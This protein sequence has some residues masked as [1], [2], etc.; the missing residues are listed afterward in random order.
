MLVWCAQKKMYTPRSHLIGVGLV[1]DGRGFNLRFFKVQN[2][3]IGRRTLIG[4]AVPWGTED[5]LRQGSEA[6]SLK[7]QVSYAGGVTVY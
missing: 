2:G 5:L 4:E 1:R 3:R 7:N 6:P